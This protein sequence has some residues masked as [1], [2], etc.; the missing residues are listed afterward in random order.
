[1][2]V[3]EWRVAGLEE[4]HL[5]LGLYKIGEVYLTKIFQFND[6]YRENEMDRLSWM[7][8]TL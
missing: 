2:A 8:I 5:Q 6:V 4:W 7:V 1:M 3:L